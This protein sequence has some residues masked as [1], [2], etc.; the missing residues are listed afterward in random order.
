MG[1]KGNVSECAYVICENVQGRTRAHEMKENFQIIEIRVFV[2]LVLLSGAALPI[3]SFLKLM[4][5]VLD[6]LK[7]S[8]F[9]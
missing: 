2:V 8:V 7:T 5:G 4:F 6:L 1:N 3:L 9:C